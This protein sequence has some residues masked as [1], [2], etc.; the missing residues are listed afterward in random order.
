[1]SKYDTFHAC[2]S[3]C[4]YVRYLERGLVSVNFPPL[5]NTC[6]G[7]LLTELQ[8]DSYVV[9]T[10]DDLGEIILV[11]LQK[12]TFL[13]RD[14]WYCRYITVTTPSGQCVEFPCFRWLVD[15]KEVVLRDGR[16]GAQWMFCF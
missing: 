1:M 7:E 15:D 13:V 5:L 9:D 12:E 3:V 6:A 10:N 14:D 16:G 8:V 2:N 4:T 11:K